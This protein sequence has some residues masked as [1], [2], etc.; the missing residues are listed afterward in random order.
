MRLQKTR[1]ISS[2]N[3]N[4]VFEY[5][6]LK[7]FSHAF[8]RCDGTRKSLQRTYDGS[9]PIMSCKEKYFHDLIDWKSQVIIID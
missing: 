7:Y 8:V 2:Q 6:N 5:T 1:H 9:Y 4:P 3:N